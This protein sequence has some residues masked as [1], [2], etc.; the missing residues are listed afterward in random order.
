VGKY[1]HTYLK[2]NVTCYNM[3]MNMTR[4]FE[5]TSDEFYDY[6]E[7]QLL[8]EI[9]KSTKKRVSLKD[10]KTGFSYRNSNAD[11]TIKIE[12]YERG[13]IYQSVAKSRTSYIRIKYQTKETKEGLEI[14][15]DQTTSNDEELDKKN[16][17][18]KAWSKTIGFGR[19]SNTLYDMRTAIINKREGIV[20]KKYQQPETHKM[21]KKFID[22]KANENEASK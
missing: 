6:L 5:I 16:K 4:T 12:E 22:K 21:L 11:S 15:F 10:I 17:L 2:T 3:V 20:T 19:M 9:K 8:E 13:R 14:S 18:Y 7:E 1:V